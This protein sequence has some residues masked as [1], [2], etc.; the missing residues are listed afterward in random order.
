MKA[1]R[2]NQMLILI[3]VLHDFC[4]VAGDH[5]IIPDSPANA[6]GFSQGGSSLHLGCENNTKQSYRVDVD[7]S[8]SI[9]NNGK[10]SFPVLFIFL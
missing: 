4:L 8:T 1:L 10:I 5:M 3:F 7:F 6:P 9:V 2:W